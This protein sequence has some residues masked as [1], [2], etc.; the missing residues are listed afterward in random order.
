MSAHRFRFFVDV[1][2]VRGAQVTLSSADA[3]HARVLRLAEGDGIDVV[4]SAGTVWDAAYVSHGAVRLI[5]VVVDGSARGGIELIAGVLTGAK[6]DELVDHAVQAGATRIVPL[7]TTP[8]DHARILARRE[9]LQR[10]AAAAAKQSHQSRIAQIASPITHAELLELEP[11]LVL[12]A[13]A[14]DRIT[15]V[16]VAS[17]TEVRVLVGPADGL[18]DTLVGELV[19]GGWR[20][21][22]LGRS[23]LRAELA[24]G[25][26]V[27]TIDMLR[28]DP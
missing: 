13:A 23:I 1:V 12:D 9:R 11:G 2:A 19:R 25:V 20:G 16:D 14:S 28:R 15:D 10:I 26:A 3:A 17:D 7:A 21:V 4:D 22:R 27:A 8:R 6:F 18:D 24:A 5:D